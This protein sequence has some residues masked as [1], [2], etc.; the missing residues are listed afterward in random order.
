MREPLQSILDQPA[1]LEKRYRENKAEFKQEFMSLYPQIQ[2]LP[3]AQVWHE[4]LR[5]QEEISWGS[6]R[7]LLTVIVIALLGG[8]IAKYPDYFGIAPDWYFPRFIAFIVFP[9][10]AL[11]FYSKG[12]IE[13]QR[14]G[15]L[16]S[17]IAL[18]ALYMNF[19]PGT[20]QSNTFVLACIHLPLLLWALAGYAYVG[21]NM[22]NM[23]AR[24]AYLRFNGELLVMVAVLFIAGL[25]LSL[26]TIGLFQLIGLHI[27]E[28]YFRHIAV[29]G[30]AG[31]P[32]IAAYLVT[33]N[34]QLVNKVSPVIAKVFTP[35]VLI[36]LT[37]YL[38]AVVYTGKDPY[39]DREF[40]LLFNALLIGVTAIIFFAVAEGQRKGEETVGTFT[41]S[42]AMLFALALLSIIINGIALSAI[43]FRIG[44]YGITP[45]RLAVLGSNF[46]LFVNL[47]L[48]CVSLWKQLRK[49]HKGESVEGAIARFLPIYTLWTFIV[50][51]LFPLLFGFK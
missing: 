51:V 7:E 38:A 6:K 50:V 44:A 24:V 47:L 19:L 37:V 26:I 11:Y 15:L 30:A 45:N 49:Q 41:I 17:V 3:T 25:L 1:A 28:F 13:N 42:K 22:L 27:E 4:R 5:Y 21:K 10:M 32:I 2:T 23:Q 48:I 20:E 40:L 31:I 46:L 16:L 29:Y 8:L 33:T 18:C 34:P 36:L 43:A 9:G 35:L 14:F 12:R 39:N